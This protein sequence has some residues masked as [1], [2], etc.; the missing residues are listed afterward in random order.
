MK[1]FFINDSTS[2]PNW[3]DRAAAISLMAMIE[4]VGGQIVGS[5]TEHDL[6]TSALGQQRPPRFDR[7]GGRQARDVLRLIVPPIIPKAARRWLPP[8]ASF[9]AGKHI[10][11]RWEDFD[12]ALKA[13]L[14]EEGVW[15]ELLGAMDASELVLIHGDGAMVGSGVIPRTDLFLS[16]VAK[17]GLGKPVAI[18]NHTADFDH[19]VLR[20]MAHNVYPRLD[21]V[22]F[23]DP[24][25]LDRCSAFCSGEVAP[26]TAFLFQPAE[27]DRWVSIASRPTYFDVWPDAAAFDPGAPYVCIGGSSI[28]GGQA[29]RGA[30]VKA[31]TELVDRLSSGYEGQIVLTVSDVVDQA[32]FRPVAERSGVP[33]I[34]LATP[35]QQAVD[36]MGNAEAYIGGRWHPSIFALRG[37]A[38]VVPLSSKTFKMEALMKMA[39]LADQAL[40]ALQLDAMLPHLLKRL[41]VYLE[42]GQG[43]R[44]ELRAWGE[45]QSLAARRHVAYIAERRNEGRPRTKV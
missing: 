34:G 25:S 6:G 33:L 32:I 3:G 23:R 13:V 9:P 24:V 40:D 41:D 22:V 39:G 15:A 21:D 8:L 29:N 7:E 45:Q 30:L 26:D 19:P 35:V 20:E 1:I 42:Q 18:V 37:G 2:N 36:I 5:L 10:P 27:G 14:G 31:Y 12:A 17:V 43:L 11:E 16:Y 28:F 38:P 4:E 44:R